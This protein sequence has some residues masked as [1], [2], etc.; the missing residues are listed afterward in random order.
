MLRRARY[1]RC[2]KRCGRTA[3]AV[4][5]LCLAPACSVWG[6][7]E[8]E[9]RDVGKMC[10]YP[11]PET[12]GVPGFG[13]GPTGP[14]DNTSFRT[15]EANQ[16]V[17]VAVHFPTCLSQSCSVN[18]QASC[19]AVFSAAHSQHLIVS[20]YGSFEQETHRPCTADCGFLIARCS[21][22]PLPAGSYT[23]EHGDVSTTLTVPTTGPPPCVDTEP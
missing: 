1:L 5:A 2:V 18:R 3:A 7:E 21:S 19:T 22:P 9:F 23:F 6:S 16:P 8:K 17:N 15:Y 13:A 4:A 14:A 10:L 20:S 11:A 12:Q